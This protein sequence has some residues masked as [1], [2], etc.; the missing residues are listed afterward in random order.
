MANEIT[1]NDL[2]TLANGAYKDNGP[3]LGSYQ[4]TQNGTGIWKRKI[5]LTGGSD[6]S[7]SAL[8]A[9]IS[10]TGLCYIINLDG[11]NYVQWGGDNGSGALS[12][13]G[14]L[15]PSVT[16]SGVTTYDIPARFRLD[17]TATLRAK[18]HT[19][20]CDILICIYND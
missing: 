20:N 9:G 8:V 6:T 11:T 18:A 17:S 10:T 15:N 16:T 5:T 7:I 2:L 1:I 4:I 19:G 14:K 13:V 3:N 12:V